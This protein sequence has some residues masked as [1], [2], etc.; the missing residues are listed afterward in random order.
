MVLLAG[1]VFV[2]GQT[3]SQKSFGDLAAALSTAFA[4]RNLGAL[5]KLRAMSRTVE[6]RIEH[7]L[8]EDGE[9]GQF[10][11]RTFKSFAA[12]EK[13]L[14]NR[15]PQAN[16]ETNP[17]TSCSKGVCSFETRGLLHNTLFLTKFTYAF[18][19]GRPY[20]RSIYIVDGD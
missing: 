5:D 12:A 13:W 14:R 6:V 20:I 15:S 9:E 16:R 3:S 2:Q 18:Y 11:S 7:S 17:L 1:T 19:K 10:E 8:A 4:E